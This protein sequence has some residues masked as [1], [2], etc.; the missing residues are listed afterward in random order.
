[1]TSTDYKQM[2]LDYINVLFFCG[3]VDDMKLEQYQ[4]NNF[5]SIITKEYYNHKSIFTKH[6]TI[7]K[8]FII[9]RNDIKHIYDISTKEKYLKIT[10]NLCKHIENRTSNIRK[11]LVM[12]W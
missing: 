8:A 6:E 11:Y 7:Y 4:E 2:K 12:K 10:N 5:I 9:K 3:I 1:M